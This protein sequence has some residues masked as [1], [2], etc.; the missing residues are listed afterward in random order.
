MVVTYQSTPCRRTE[1]QTQ[2]F[3]LPENL[4]FR[5]ERIYDERK[6]EGEAVLVLR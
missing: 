5:S 2:N 1:G 6:F 4:K 3:Q